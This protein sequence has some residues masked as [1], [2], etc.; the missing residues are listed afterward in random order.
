MK[1][2]KKCFLYAAVVTFLS[3]A[4]SVSYAAFQ[5]APLSGDPGGGDTGCPSQC[6]S[7]NYCGSG[8]SCGLGGKCY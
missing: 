1:K 7:M 5:D 6:G 8:C 3:G 2:I 4:A